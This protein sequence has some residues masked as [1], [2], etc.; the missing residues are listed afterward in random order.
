MSPL[1]LERKSDLRCPRCGQPSSETSVL[2]EPHRLDAA[3]RV[4]RSATKRRAARRARSEC[5]MCGAASTGYRCLDCA[6]KLKLWR[7]Q[8]EGSAA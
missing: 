7:G 3:G 2:C 4:Q 6:L 1:Y 8:T 5:A